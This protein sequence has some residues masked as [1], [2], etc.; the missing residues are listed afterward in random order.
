MPDRQDSTVPQ[1]PLDT[2]IR[3]TY[4]AGFDDPAG[5]EALAQLGEALLSYAREAGLWG[6]DFVRTPLTA[7]AEDLDGLAACL[8][9]VH[10]APSESVI[11]AEDLG[12]CN[13]AG[14]WAEHVRA[15]VLE[16]RAGLAAG[17]VE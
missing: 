12:L 7:I 4:A 3:A 2:P 6:A 15:V 1:S 8:A 5:V 14:A 17:E 11:Q 16:I 13:E 9:E 10:D